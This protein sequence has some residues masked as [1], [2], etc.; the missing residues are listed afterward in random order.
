[1]VDRNEQ[2]TLAEHQGECSEVGAVPGD[3]VASQEH[4]E[5][6]PN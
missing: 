2:I 3:P 1:M 5:A 6:M 4:A